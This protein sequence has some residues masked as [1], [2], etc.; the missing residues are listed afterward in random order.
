ME[1]LKSKI[2]GYITDQRNTTHPIFCDVQNTDQAD[3]IFDGI[4]YAKGAALLKQLFTMMGEQK[5]SQAMG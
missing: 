4:T 3:N 1:F 2:W 5:F